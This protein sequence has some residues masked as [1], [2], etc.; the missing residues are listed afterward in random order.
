MEQSIAVSTVVTS[1]EIAAL[2]TV[3]SSL[4]LNDPW[5]W[6]VSSVFVH[7]PPNLTLDSVTHK[8]NR[9]YI[10]I[11]RTRLFSGP[12]DIPAKLSQSLLKLCAF[13]LL[14]DFYIVVMLDVDALVTGSIS[15]ALNN[16]PN[17]CV[18][19]AITPNWSPRN[20]PPSNAH[21]TTRRMDSNPVVINSSN[22]SVGKGG[23]EINTGMLIVKSCSCLSTKS[24]LRL[25]RQLN[26]QH[27]PKGDQTVFN[28]YLRYVYR[29]DVTVLPL[30]FNMLAHFLPDSLL[31]SCRGANA[32]SS[33][34]C[35]TFP[36]LRMIHYNGRKKPW[37]RKEK[38][39]QAFAQHKCIWHIWHELANIVAKNDDTQSSE[40]NFGET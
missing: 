39:P 33:A 40:G 19:G 2:G 23:G 8:V 15:E 18:A 38:V 37:D 34:L 35:N 32:A 26:V 6:R 11:R 28:L 27:L 36:N 1:R 12:L 4:C 7:A 16:L 21:Q 17:T 31:P 30:R 24:M 10:N 5:L 9:K 22:L 29:A 20:T 25:L 14:Q 13:D 3:L